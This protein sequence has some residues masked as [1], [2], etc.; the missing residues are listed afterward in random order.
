MSALAVV[1]AHSTIV[2][3]HIRYLA[4]LPE[5]VMLG[6]AVLLLGIASL[7]RRPLRVTVSTVGTIVIAGTSLG[8]ALWQWPTS[9]RTVPT[10]PST[11]RWWSTA[12]A[13]SS[14]SRWRA[15]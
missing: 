6:G 4:I 2:L 8:L 15:P 7:V 9:P 12:S 5:I 11:T 14:P 1:T 10:R 13:S 3:P